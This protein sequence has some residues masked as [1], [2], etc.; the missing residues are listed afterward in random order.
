MEPYL[1]QSSAIGSSMA[2][3][4]EGDEPRI[5]EA[6]TVLAA[7]TGLPLA[8]RAERGG[9]AVLL[10]VTED[11]LELRWGAA[12]RTGPVYAE[13][14]QGQM[15][16]R[17]RNPVA[18][19]RMLA[20]AV[21]FK[22]K[23]LTVVD[24][25]AGLGRDAFLLA[26]MGCEVTAVERS[27]V[28]AAVLGDGLR[29]ARCDA[30]LSAMIGRN[31]RVVE[32]DARDYLQGLSATDRPQV[33]CLDP[34]FPARSK[35]ALVKKEMRMC[36]LVTGDDADAGELLDIARSVARSRVVVKR[37]LKAPLLG[38]DPDITYKGTTIRY[39]IYLPVA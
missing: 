37:P 1:H 13:F 23:P 32:S 2:V 36:R 22:G 10:T 38:G 27:P 29:R 39:D 31:L 16:H 28:M 35:S 7:Q 4:A 21:G 34:M 18:A 17:R 24:A 3:T 20:K 26:C 11:R 33:I 14:L 30:K 15:Q 8:T 9:Y 12:P 25:T 6:A 5:A 19:E